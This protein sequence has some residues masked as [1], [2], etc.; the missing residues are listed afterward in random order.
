MKS[1]R[2]AILI[3]GLLLPY[4]ARIPGTFVHGSD[5]LTSYFGD[6]LMAIPLL[7]GFNAIAIGAILLATLTYRVKYSAWF[8][9]LFGF[10]Y[11]AYMH[12]RLDLASDAQA[13]VALVFIPI[14]ALPCTLAGWVPGFIF[15]LLW[16]YFTR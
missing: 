14:L 3:I 5:W 16:R 13:P 15:D 6:N 11:L 7:E 9:A 1:T 12:S 2:I 4:A 10:A 8:P